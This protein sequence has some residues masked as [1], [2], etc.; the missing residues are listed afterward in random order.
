MTRISLATPP[1]SARAASPA[2]APILPPETART[3]RSAAA[4]R[5]PGPWER[6]CARRAADALRALRAGRIDLRLPD[7]RVETFGDAGAAPITLA[8]ADW[9]LF[10][11]LAA[12]GEIALG[13]SYVDGLWDTDDLAGLITLFHR[14]AELFDAR[15][16]E[17]G[18]VR[19]VAERLLRVALRN[20]RDGSRR[21]VAAH[22]DL[23][24]D[25]FELFLDESMSYSSALYA[26]PDDTL[27]RAQQRKIE[28]MLDLAGVRAGD[29]V[30]EI[31]C[32]WGALAVAAARRGARVTGLTL[33]ENQDAA[34]RRRA[35]AAGLAD[36]ITIE[37]RDYR[38]LGSR[39]GERHAFD[40]I[41]SVEMI[42]A[43]GHRY[44]PAFFAACERV[45]APRGRVALQAITVPDQ[46]YDAYRRGS[47][48]LRKHVFPG[49]LAPSLTALC[50]AATAGSSLVVDEARNI[51]PHYA[52]TL[53]DWRAR[54]EA[55]AGDAAR[56]GY[57]PRFRRLWRYYLAYCE[58]GF[59]AG[60]FGDLQLA[61]TRPAARAIPSAAAL[62][63][64]GCEVPA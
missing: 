15:A 44:L 13:E 51:G 1:H 10:R 4:A 39:P 20:T 16:A 18:P 63:G 7:G 14:D 8:V 52:R 62:A 12:G 57:G 46:R 6:F 54:F 9:A 19:C 35:A 17:A 2:L 21:N 50:A 38:D 31:G 41:V 22:Y 26:G 34:A 49:G 42:E 60:T 28:A 59:A 53:A 43:V 3:P 30:L 40:R 5:R 55:R 24:D 56:L 36:R 45:L 33:S 27:E 58:A 64:H 32:G 61:L 47:D 23:G 37:R 29:R 48:W 25:L 11:R